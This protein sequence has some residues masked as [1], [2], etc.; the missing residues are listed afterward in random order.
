M[1]SDLLKGYFIGSVLKIDK[2]TRKLG[3]YIPKLM[4]TLSEGSVT[5]YTLPTNSGLSVGEFKTNVSS[6]ITKINYIMAKPEDW[7]T[8]L[9]AIGSKVMV[10]F[11]DSAPSQAIWAVFNPNG[12]NEV[13]AE[14]RYPKMFSL[15][16][17]GK[18]I[19]VSNS[20]S[21]T[22]TLPEYL[23]VA[24]YSD[25][26]DPKSKTIGIIADKAFVNRTK[27]LQEEVES[28]RK[29]IDC[30]I[31][32]SRDDALAALSGIAPMAGMPNPYLDRFK[33]CKNVLI[34][35]IED[36]N[37]LMEIRSAR[38]LGKAVLPGLNELYSNYR[39]IYSAYS[40]L[41]D[42][43]KELI[44]DFSIGNL[45]SAMD[46]AFIDS[47]TCT[48]S[49]PKELSQ[50]KGNGLATEFDAEYSW[51][52]DDGSEMSST[53]RKSIFSKIDAYSDA[54]IGDSDKKPTFPTSALNDILSMTK[55][56]GAA[57]STSF[58]KAFIHKW[59]SGDG[60]P[61]VYSDKLIA[62]KYFGF[63]MAVG[64]SVKAVDEGFGYEYE[65][66]LDSDS[67]GLTLDELNS[68]ISEIDDGGAAEHTITMSVIGQDK[69]VIETLTSSFTKS[70]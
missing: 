25:A 50:L 11:I 56:D 69:T 2:E 70:I 29:T 52:G 47:M 19:D 10:Y 51:I 30:M 1:A 26:D 17:G 4:P 7:D 62:A 45:K 64:C 61:I 53:V 57:A 21:I 33:T 48:D 44:P 54:D 15:T 28:L 20:D 46:G 68:K 37:D 27:A 40:A 66:A 49:L 9:P 18:P 43:V 32:D 59:S 13:I 31:D 23:T 5:S 60:T 55:G 67:T 58:C 3:V 24:S 14:E 22:I 34:N 12:D 16:I 41:T 35:R 36:A 38:R 42:A 8:P 39:S 6:T 65:F 63:Y